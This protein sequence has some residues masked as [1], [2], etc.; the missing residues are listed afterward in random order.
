MASWPNERGAGWPRDAGGIASAG[1][2]PTGGC[3]S[4]HAAKRATV[5]PRGES[6]SEAAS[7]VKAHGYRGL[8]M[9]TTLSPNGASGTLS[10]VKQDG[11]DAYHLVE[12]VATRINAR[13]GT[14]D[15][16][17]IA[18]NFH[19]EYGRTTT[20]GSRTPDGPTD[21]TKRKQ[22]VSQNVSGLRPSTLYHFR[23]KSCDA[24]GNLATSD[25]FSFTTGAAT[26]LLV[27]R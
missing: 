13:T 9:K 10:V 18:T 4:I 16:N 24:A 6:K 1:R 5:A 11:P 7:A 8:L 19:F 26:A 20:Y 23:V 3:S 14:V 21:P 25:D 15:P 2:R 17:H 22:T 12:T 27:S